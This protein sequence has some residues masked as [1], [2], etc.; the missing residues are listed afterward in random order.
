M[1]T[2]T[3][4]ICCLFLSSGLSAQNEI[5][6]LSGQ[7]L[8][9]PQAGSNPVLK[10]PGTQ[11]EL[12]GKLRSKG[13]GSAKLVYKGHY[14]WVKGSKMRN[15]QD[16]VNAA[17]MSNE[18][19]FSGRFF[20]FLTESVKEGENPETVKKHHRKYMSKSSGGIKGYTNREYAISALL[21][22]AGKLPA[23]NVLFKWRN[24]TGE[25]PYTFQ[26]LAP[27]GKQI[28]QVLVRDTFLTLDLDQLSMDI[29]AEYEWKVTRGE[30]IRS[31]SIPIEICPDKAKELYDEIS[32]EEEFKSADPTEQQLMFAYILE[33]ERCFYKANKTY[34]HLLSIDPTNILLRKMYSTFLA[35]MDM[36]PEANA[37]IQR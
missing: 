14:F 29:F 23:A 6:V 2:V 30:G 7:V 28:A 25:G 31:A 1:R 4:V 20:N 8:Y 34:E 32:Q 5:T 3:L 37:F 18:M 13:T 10:N 15:V 36:L 17:A 22:S 33:E 24:T 16:V 19:S 12:K 26:L 27:G 9:Y 35:R 21:L 11:F